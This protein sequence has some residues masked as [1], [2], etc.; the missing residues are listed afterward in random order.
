MS[1]RKIGW[2]GIAAVLL[3]SITIIVMAALRTDG[4]NHFHKAVSELGSIDAPNMWIFNILGYIIPGILISIFGFKFTTAFQNPNLKSYPFYLLGISGLLMCLAG[5]FPV[6][7]ENRRSIISTIHGIGAMA[8][9]GFWLL[10]ALTIWWQL[11]KIDGWKV[12]AYASFFI[13]FIMIAAMSLVPE[14]MPGLAQRFSFGANYFFIL[15]LGIKI[16][17]HKS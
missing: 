4:Y 12:A 7:M 10:S 5:V 14:N 13:P 15:I 8:S 17:Y 11:K 6:D 3:G 9:G 1:T 2:I 16:L